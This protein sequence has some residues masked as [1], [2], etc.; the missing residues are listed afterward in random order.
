[1]PVSVLSVDDCPQIGLAMERWMLTLAD[2]TWLGWVQE[3]EEA[4]RLIAEREPDVVLLDLDMPGNPVEVLERA[5]KANR[6]TKYVMLSAHMDP[7]QIQRCW[8]A[9]AV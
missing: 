8:D 3:L 6:A 9:G 2:F 7:R 1:M 5:K 4:E